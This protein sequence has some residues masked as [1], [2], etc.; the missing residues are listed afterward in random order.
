[1]RRL[2]CWFGLHLWQYFDWAKFSYHG[3]TQGVTPT[4]RS[5]DRCKAAHWY[6]GVAMKWRRIR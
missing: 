5:C 1:M 6:D 2:A 4:K 3:R